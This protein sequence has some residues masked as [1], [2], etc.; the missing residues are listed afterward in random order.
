MKRTLLE[1][2][3]KDGVPYVKICDQV[4]D[5][6]ESALLDQQAALLQNVQEVFDT[7]VMDFDQMFVVEELPDPR[8]DNSCQQ[9]QEFVVQ[10]NA[11]LNGPI[12]REFA[13]ATSLSAP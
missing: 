10:A 2:A 1:Q 9:I 13:A 3:I 5:T 12:E 8:R 7:V 4:K 11:R 6:V